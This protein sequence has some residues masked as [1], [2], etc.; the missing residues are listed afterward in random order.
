[1][2]FQTD[3]NQTAKTCLCSVHLAGYSY[4]SQAMRAP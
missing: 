4:Q 1:L 2:W 3:A